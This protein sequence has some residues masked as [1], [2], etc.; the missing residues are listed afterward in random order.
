MYIF[1]YHLQFLRYFKAILLLF[2]FSKSICGQNASKTTEKVLHPIDLPK[3][4]IESQ[5]EIQ[6]TDKKQNGTP[7]IYSPTTHYNFG[8][9]DNSGVIE[10]GFPIH[11]KGDATLKINNIRAHC[12]CTTTKL[13]QKEIKPGESIIL[14]SKLSLKKRLGKQK[15]QITVYSN[16]PKNPRYALFIEGEATAK[17]EIRPYSISFYSREK[18]EINRTVRLH[19]NEDSPFIIESLVLSLI[20]I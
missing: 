1:S 17:V 11:N 2:L 14:E 8:Q 7:I 15:K 20:H 13:D 19:S 4:K 5:S 3:T 10:Y 6:Q 18:N 9:K 16:D 12:G